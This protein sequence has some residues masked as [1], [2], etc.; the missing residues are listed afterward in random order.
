M[1]YILANKIKA[2]EHGFLARLHHCTIEQ[3][4]LNEREVMRSSKL[5]G[6]LE[7]RVIPL[8]GIILDNNQAK[9][10]INKIK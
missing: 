3:M 1:K 2:Q 9:N 5:N 7:E 10:V 4:M 8:E 6:N